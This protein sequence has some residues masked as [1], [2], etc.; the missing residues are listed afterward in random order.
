MGRDLL[1][2]SAPEV[3]PHS[4]LDSRLHRSSPARLSAEPLGVTRVTGKARQ[5][6]HASLPALASFH[7]NPR[8]RPGQRS[9]WKASC[10]Q[11]HMV[12]LIF[13]FLLSWTSTSSL[14]SL[15]AKPS[16]PPAFCWC[17]CFFLITLRKAA[18][19]NREAECSVK[20]A[21]KGYSS[22]ACGC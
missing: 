1:S 10:T 20:E 7:R 2:Q 17:V 13:L 12:S 5:R 11:I 14:C 9:P 19:R 16:L 15:Q 3:L 4:S 6:L 21:A 18:Q 22:S 8:T